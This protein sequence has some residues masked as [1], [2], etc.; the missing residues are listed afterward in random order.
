M[1]EKQRNE[2]YRDVFND[3]WCDVTMRP[4]LFTRHR[5]DRKKKIVT[6]KSLAKERTRRPLVRCDNEAVRCLQKKF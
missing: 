4:L 3:H 5:T 6:E 1:K 2:H